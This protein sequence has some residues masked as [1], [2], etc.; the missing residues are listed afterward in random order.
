MVIT[1][2]LSW[3]L[4]SATEST[5]LLLMPVSVISFMGIKE[6][7][8]GHTNSDC[9]H[10]SLACLSASTYIPLVSDIDG[11]RQKV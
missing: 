1:G 5:L 2:V 11:G 10:C 7:H 9:S 3:A 4:C 8:Y 6:E